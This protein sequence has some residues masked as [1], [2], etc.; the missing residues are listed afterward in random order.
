MEL[1]NYQKQTLEM[2]RGYLE[3]LSEARRNREQ[4]KALELDI[5]F[6]WTREAWKRSGAA[7]TTITCA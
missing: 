7:P 2:L 5:A 6:E 4:I 1:R 3:A